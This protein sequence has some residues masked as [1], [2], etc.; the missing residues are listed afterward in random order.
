MSSLAAD[1]S[2]GGLPVV[3]GS[4]WSVS[5]SELSG[6]SV[7]RKQIYCSPLAAGACLIRKASE[8]PVSGV[9]RCVDEKGT[10]EE[11]RIG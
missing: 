3:S 2:S 10:G 11:R 7:A 1:V 6:S 8:L 9:R 4:V 5:V